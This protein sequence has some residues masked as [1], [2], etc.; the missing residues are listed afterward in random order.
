M[1]NLLSKNSSFLFWTYKRE[2]NGNTAEAYDTPIIESG[3]DSRLKEKLKIVIAPA[4]RSEAIETKAKAA[5]ELVDK[6]TVL[7]TERPITLFTELK[8]ILK[9]IFGKDFLSIINGT[10]IKACKN[11]PIATPKP[12]P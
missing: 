2:S 8:S 9:V 11:A 10:W 7:G 1:L 12:K 4:P 6:V 3:P 5:I